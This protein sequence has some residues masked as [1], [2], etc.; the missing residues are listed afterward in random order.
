[1]EQVTA[2]AR[3]MVGRWGMSE[4]V[5]AMTVLTREG[6]PRQLGISEA[7]L[8]DV[9]DEARRIIA[10]CQAEALQLLAENRDR[11]DAIVAELMIH[12]TLD[13]EQAY[14]AAGLP[15]PTPAHV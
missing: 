11:L 14:R 13:E 4:K 10:E 15:R 12:E 2:I 5:G 8:A 7:T 1:M 9:D 6:D 3:Q